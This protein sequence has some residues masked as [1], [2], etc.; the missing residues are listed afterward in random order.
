[1][2]CEHFVHFVQFK[3]AHFI[4]FYQC[5]DFAHTPSGYYRRLLL[6]SGKQLPLCPD[7]HVLYIHS[8]HRHSTIYS[9]SPYASKYFQIVTVLDI[10]TGTSHFSMNYVP[11]F[12]ICFSPILFRIHQNEYPLI[13]FTFPVS[14]N[15]ILLILSRF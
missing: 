7:T 4:H 15:E 13:P 10:S 1:M 11:I 8:I 2:K 6:F 9:S 5:P 14:K 3:T 12:V